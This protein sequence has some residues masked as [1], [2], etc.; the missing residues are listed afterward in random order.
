MRDRF[1]FRLKHLGAYGTLLMFLS[2]GFAQQ[3][4]PP[5]LKDFG[6]SLKRIKWDD[7]KN[8]AVEIK[9]KAKS[10]RG[11]DDIDVLKVETSLV[12]NDVLVLD[13]KGNFVSDL[14]AQDFRIAED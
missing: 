7:Q 6:S 14:T 11:P 12:S 10:K 4:E 5:K 9:S 3:Q 13:E 1:H 2:T 8:T